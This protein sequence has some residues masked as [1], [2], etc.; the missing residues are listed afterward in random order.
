[1]STMILWRLVVEWL[2]TFIF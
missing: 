1:M 2:V